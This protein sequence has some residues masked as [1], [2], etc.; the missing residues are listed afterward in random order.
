MGY[1][2]VLNIQTRGKLI[3]E[4][5][6][7]LNGFAGDHEIIF[8]NAMALPGLINSH[9]HLDFNLFPQ[10]GDQIYSNYVEWGETIHLHHK[11]QI[12]K[13]LKVPA[14]LRA[15]WGIYK[16]LLCGVTTVVDH[17]KKQYKDRPLITVFDRCQSLHS[18]KLEK[19]WRLRLNNP[20]KMNVPAVIHI[21]EGTDQ[22]SA[23]E[24][25]ELICQNKL[26]RKIIGVHGVAMNEQQA[27]HFKALVW[28]L[29]TNYFLLNRTASVNKLKATVPILF[30][31]DSTLTANWDIWDHIRMTKKTAFLTD[32]E[33][34]Q[35]LTS[36]AAKIWNIN[37]G[38]IARGKL[39]DIVVVDQ[40]D[41]DDLTSFF[42]IEPEAIL[43]VMHQGEIRLFDEILF[44]Q[45]T[46]IDLSSFNKI[47]MNGV[48]KYV[49]GDLPG[50]IEQIWQYYPEARF[51][52]GTF[53]Q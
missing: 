47:K 48:V 37:S 41:G 25:D 3:S 19:R 28:C 7:S 24:I 14:A 32:D 18:V 8:A 23:D 20:F 21:G 1:K 38:N 2:G 45:L 11:E 31:T 6:D 40:S 42:K 39:A 26:R 27:Q 53:Q 30:G 35:S 29:Q 9:D 5:S 49:Q 52:I 33:L 17:G 16:N 36:T 22:A 4:V 46:H 12:N 34:Y 51:P 44:G 13:V 10:L 15:Q 43:M 50:L